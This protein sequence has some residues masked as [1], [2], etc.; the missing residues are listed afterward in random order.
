MPLASKLSHIKTPI[1]IGLQY[2]GYV[3]ILCLSNAKTSSGNDFRNSF[4]SSH[5]QTNLGLAH[6]KLQS[7]GV[8]GGL[9]PSSGGVLGDQLPIT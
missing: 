2:H 7:V 4:L 5:S 8:V 3:I 6:G 9:E 1:H